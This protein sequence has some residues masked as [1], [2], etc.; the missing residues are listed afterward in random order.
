MKR[1]KTKLIKQFL[2]AGQWNEKARKDSVLYIDISKNWDHFSNKSIPE[3][4]LFFKAYDFINIFKKSPSF[5]F[6][7]RLAIHPSCVVNVPGKGFFIRVR[8]DLPSS[9]L[10][11]S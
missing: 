10:L 4:K 2:A 11:L 1:G 6:S 7:P 8:V 9:I 3:I 5:F